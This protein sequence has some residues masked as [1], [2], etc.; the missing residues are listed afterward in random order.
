MQIYQ[1]KGNEMKK[2]ILIILVTINLIAFA[3]SR[4]IETPD[5]K[6]LAVSDPEYNRMIEEFQKWENENISINT[7]GWMKSKEEKEN[8]KTSYTNTKQDNFFVVYEEASD[9]SLTEFINLTFKLNQKN[10][11]KLKIEKQIYFNSSGRNHTQVIMTAT[12]AGS[13][14]SY[15]YNI[16]TIKGGYTIVVG[17]T[18]GKNTVQLEELKNKISLK[19]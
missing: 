7:S 12:N 16:Y 19:N 2:M 5:G 10:N 11:R 1:A 4:V 18:T 15:V 9:S 14:V 17:W 3:R 8:Y 13:S 6:R